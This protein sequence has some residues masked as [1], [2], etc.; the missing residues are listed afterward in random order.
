MDAVGNAQDRAPGALVEQRIS[1]EGRHQLM[2]GRLEQGVY[3]GGGGVPGVHPAFEAQH[4]CGSLQARPVL[5]RRES[6]AAPMARVKD[7]ALSPLDHGRSI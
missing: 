3:G 6:H 4:Q 2:P 5:D 7:W 1:I